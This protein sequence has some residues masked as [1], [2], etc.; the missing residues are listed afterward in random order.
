MQEIIIFGCLVL[1]LGL[2]I[3]NKRG[4]KKELIIA[5]FISFFWVYFSGLY[6]YR[7]ANFMIGSFNL[8]PFVAW[9]TGLVILREVY[10]HVNIQNKFYIISV[11]YMIL[12][13]I[14]EYVG[15]NLW[16]IQLT[17]NYSGLFGIEMMHMP[18]YGQLYYLLIGPTYLFLTDYLKVN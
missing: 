13:M 1:L 18:L 12:L 10:E 17:T 5:S 7:D 6:V 3:K 4:I 8:F 11:V 2:Y 9:T 16:K 15:Y 14:I